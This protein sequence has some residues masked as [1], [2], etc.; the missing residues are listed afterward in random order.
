MSLPNPTKQEYWGGSRPVLGTRAEG[1][2]GSHDPSLAVLAAC[3]TAPSPGGSNTGR[4]REEG[5]VY[6]LLC[7]RAA[8]PVRT[9][10]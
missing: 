8:E 5:N 10:R 6:Q 9:S 3:A 2:I 7:Q 1:K 4:E